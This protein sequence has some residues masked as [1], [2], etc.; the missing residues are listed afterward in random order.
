MKCPEC[1]TNWKY[2]NGM[3]CKCGYGFV[4]SPKID[5]I[6][7]GKF[8]FVIRHAN[9]NG[10][11]YFTKEQLFTSYCIKLNQ[12]NKT[13]IIASVIF[14]LLSL[15]FTYVR[16]YPLVFIFGS[17]CIFMIWSQIIIKGS[18]KAFNKNLEKWQRKKGKIE[19]MII[20]PSLQSPPPKWNTEDIY[21]YGVE[22]ILIVQGNI[23]VDMFVL[24]DF[25]S[26]QRC[27]VLSETGYPNYICQRA[28]KILT[29]NKD[30]SVYYLHDSTVEGINS[31][32]DLKK[33]VLLG[34]QLKNLMDIGLSPKD[35]NDIPLIKTAV[36]IKKEK[37]V[38]ANI[39]PYTTLA[40][41]TGLAME[42]KTTITDVLHRKD[43]SSDYTFG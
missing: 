26:E 25:H 14:G 36:K 11:V 38:P 42:N 8:N 30:I 40:E 9:K 17:I 12:L 22:K 13:E 41:L 37:G 34:K 23:L 10:T 16:I 1:S 19:K 20:K 5:G 2:R 4:F 24:N 15:F 39:I 21:D 32:D 6:A 43:I 33:S 35:I 31:F 28:K 7:D 27:I 3:T 18:E 29:D